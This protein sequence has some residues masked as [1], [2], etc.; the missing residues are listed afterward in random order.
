MIPEK[1]GFQQA[2]QTGHM[3]GQHNSLP[4]SGTSSD[5]CPKACKSSFWAR[6]TWPRLLTMIAED[7]G[8]VQLLIISRARPC[9]QALLFLTFALL[10][11]L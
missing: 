6:S 5:R 2:S 8:R 11:A 7:S 9:R 4:T 3:P 10:T 1:H